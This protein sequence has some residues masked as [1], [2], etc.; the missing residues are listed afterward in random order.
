MSPHLLLP[1]L[2]LHRLRRHHQ[3]LHLSSGGMMHWVRINSSS[4]SASQWHLLTLV[5]RRLAQSMRLRPAGAR[6]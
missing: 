6:V 5:R 4:S 2:L 1:L 3:P